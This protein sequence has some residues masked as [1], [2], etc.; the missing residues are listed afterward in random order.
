M[1]LVICDI[2]IIFASICDAHRFKEHAKSSTLARMEWWNPAKDTLP[3]T[4]KYVLFTGDAGGPNNI[5][6]GWEMTGVVAKATG[7][8]LVIPPPWPMYLLDFGPRSL[9]PKELKGKGKGTT[10]MEDLINLDQLKANLPTLTAREFE[11]REGVSWKEAVHQ[12]AQSKTK[13]DIGAYKKV[14]SKFLMMSGEG[15]IREG[16]DCGVWYQNGGPNDVLKASMTNDEWGLL[17]HGFVWH[18][19]IFQVASKVVE[20]LGI[21]KYDALHARY[22]DFQFHHDQQNTSDI[23][24]K[25]SPIFRSS[26]K[27]WVSSDELAKVAKKHIDGVELFTFD[28]LTS[29]RTNFLLNE[30]K[31]GFDPVRWFEIRGPV[32]EL[33]CTYS[34]VFV[35][36][37]SSTFSGHIDRMRLNAQAPVTRKLKHKSTV[38]DMKSIDKDVK[39][40]A[41]QGRMSSYDRT[42]DTVMFFSRSG[43]ADV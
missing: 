20:F 42:H 30:T 35:G 37:G 22:N 33:I 31:A 3:P 23:F 38:P 7:R 4:E 25:W 29:S 19:D 12:S 17:K 15:K 14:T 6:I 41:S 13:C 36:T 43:L 18:A 11:A 1:N 27:L 10:A 2:L 9:L 39:A 24:Q 28:D 40:W 21:F 8:T 34:R 32:E 5:R 26:G 16:F